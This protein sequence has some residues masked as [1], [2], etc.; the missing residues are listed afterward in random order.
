MQLKAGAV[1]GMDR[2]G[3]NEWHTKLVASATLSSTTDKSTGRS[4]TSSTLSTRVNPS[5]AKM[6]AQRRNGSNEMLT[7]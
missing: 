7:M 5:L 3:I 4:L 6:L 1:H 2:L